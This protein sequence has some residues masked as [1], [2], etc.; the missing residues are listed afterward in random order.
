MKKVRW[1]KIWKWTQIALLIYILLGVALYFLQDII[2]FRPVKLPADYT[3]K[4]DQPFREEE[5]VVNEDKV[6]SMVHFTVPDSLRKGIVLYF[7][8]NRT[9]INRYAPFAKFFTRNGYETWMIDYPGYGK[10][11]GKRTEKILHE[12]ALRFYKLAI[13]RVPAE[14]IIIY[15]KS[16]GS[17]IAARLASIRDCKRLI[18]ETPYYSMDAMGRHYF[19]IYPVNPM[20]KFALATNENFPFI[21]APVT[22]FHGTKDRVIPYNHA[23]RLAKLSSDVELVTIPGGRHNNLT[24]YEVYGHKM[25]SLLTN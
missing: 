3:Y 22:I 12:D 4:F 7:H 10:S 16:L 14:R 9:N 21:H 11:T 6:I 5:I 19:F 1:K 2:I 17:G 8:G 23:K 18:L 20:S 24:E 25:D 13:A 15:G